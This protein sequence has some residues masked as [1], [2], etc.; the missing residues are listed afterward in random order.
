MGNGGLHADCTG[1]NWHCDGRCGSPGRPGAVTA[2]SADAYVYWAN[3]G[4]GK[5]IGRAN[6]DGTGA[7][8]TFITGVGDPQGLAVDR[9][10]IYWANLGDRLDRPREHRRHR[11]PPDLHHRG[12][13]AEGRGRRRQAHLLG[14]PRDELDRAGQPRRD[15]GAHSLHR[16]GRLSPGCR[17]DAH[18]LYWSE[19]R[20]AI[21]RASLDGSN[22]ERD[23]VTG[24]ESPDLMDAYRGYLYWSNQRGGSI[25]RASL[26]GGPVTQDFIPGATKPLGV[27]ADDSGVYWANNGTGTIGHANL[28][29]SQV[30]PNFI[31]EARAPIGIAVDAGAD[32]SP[33]QTRIT[34]GIRKADRRRPRQV[35]VPLLGA[36][37]RGSSA[38][39]TRRSGG[40]AGRR[41][42][43]STSTRAGTCSGF[44]PPI[45]PATSIP[46][47]PGTSSR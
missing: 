41:E 32:K 14:E 3:S 1:S 2:T 18:Y 25:G 37:V 31:T 11:R 8:R 28:D 33:P 20:S 7:N 30:T 16:R 44:G 39:S 34:T 5:S 10:H 29:G 19:T 27:A 15:R 23:F 17:R 46:P 26:T 36:S 13:L 45:S 6:P 4:G 40:A 24:A 21:G 22:I 12:E 35:Q 9:K 43:S 47:P 38:G 42:R